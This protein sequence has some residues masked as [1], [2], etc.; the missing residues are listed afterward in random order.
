MNSHGVYE[1]NRLM[2]A[3]FRGAE[4]AKGRKQHRAWARR[5]SSCETRSSA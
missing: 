4:L 2:Q 5:T 1:L 3:T